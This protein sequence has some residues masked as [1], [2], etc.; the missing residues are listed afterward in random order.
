MNEKRQSP[1]WRSGIFFLCLG[2]SVCFF[3]LRMGLG[4]PSAPGPGFM[5]FAA[6][7]F[8][9]FLSLLLLLQI[10]LRE[11]GENWETRIALR[12]AVWVIGGMAAFG[13]LLPKIGFVF[14]T[15]GFVTLL[16]RFINPQSWRKA[17]IAGAGSSGISFLLF[18]I[19]LKT[20]LPRTF[21]GFF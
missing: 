14:V 20:P 3:S 8:L 13:F 12:N 21:L 17:V 4:K 2:L 15:F 16:I 11:A 9:A 19:L 10:L 6:G 7:L 18:D 1:D 5:P